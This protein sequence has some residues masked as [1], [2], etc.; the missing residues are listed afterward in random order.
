MTLS[1][2]AFPI[3]LRPGANVYNRGMHLAR[4]H[5]ENFRAIRKASLDLDETTVLIGEN[6]SGRSSILEA[7]ALVLQP[8]NGPSGFGFEAPHWR[9]SVLQ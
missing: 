4:I 3:L 7:L 8:R 5:I 6:N 2:D 9:W 1:R